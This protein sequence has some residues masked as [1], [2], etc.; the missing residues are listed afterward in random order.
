[1]STSKMLTLIDYTLFEALPFGFFA[2]GLVLTFRYLKLI[3]LTFAAS[4]ALGPAVLARLLVDG[5]GFVSAF[6]AATA[7]TIL[8]SLLTLFLLLALRIDGLLAGLVSSF[9]GY[10]LALLFTRG[11][12][13]FSGVDT[14]LTYL[15]QLDTEW[16]SGRAP[17]HP[18]Q[19]GAFAA[20]CI[21]VKKAADIFLHSE[22]G[23]AYRA[24][25]DEK[26]A[27][28]LLPSLRIS[29]D[30]LIAGGVVAGN[31]LCMLSGIA[32]AL[33][34][35]QAT[36]QRGFDALLTV[37]AAYLLG[38]TLFEKRPT[39]AMAGVRSKLAHFVKR[40]QRMETTSA[41][42]VGLLLYFGLLQSISRLDV[43]SSIP[44]LIVVGLL[45]ASF[46]ASRWGELRTRMM[47]VAGD[48]TVPASATAALVAEDVGV[49]YPAFPEPIR[50]LGGASIRVAPGELVQLTGPNGS[51]KS[52][53][54][55]YLAGEISGQGCVAVPGVTTHGNGRLRH[56][57]VALIHQDSSAATCAALTAREHLALYLTAQNA[58]AI[59]TW[60]HAVRDWDQASIAAN[61]ISGFSGV[62]VAGLSG[63]QRQVLS[64]VSL[65]VRPHAPR[66]VLLDEPLTHLD[67]ANA[68]I[69]VDLIEEL[70]GRGCGV[71]LVQH[72]LGANHEDVHFQ[73]EPDTSR[74]RLAAMVT[75][76]VRIDEIQCARPITS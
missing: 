36:A 52:T 34:E 16:F 15:M 11:S 40:L 37:I 56:G 72:D 49:T 33:K 47:G 65:L 29:P 41:A 20:A 8:L 14:P 62:P 38:V 18:W 70:L 39:S 13:S 46:T 3:D 27:R 58:S 12:L 22:A 76:R 28:S 17:L 75:R 45:V 63:G 2:I 69:C 54:L 30:R 19:I 74:H 24:L 9:A 64:V 7:L 59:R 73:A 53:L 67:E 42:L 6:A 55:R 4:F 32:V 71:V 25:E 57:A 23:L 51:G 26:S 48:V 50:V 66:I 44:K 60:R 1:M 43:P 68:R 35:T 61:P 5:H 31:F 10:A 21:V